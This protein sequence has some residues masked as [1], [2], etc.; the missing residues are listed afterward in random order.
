M[1][2]KDVE[3]LTVIMTA[4]HGKA[5][6]AIARKRALRCKRM[7]ENDWAETWNAVAGRIVD[8]LQKPHAAD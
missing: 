6:E 3:R 5:A 4:R 7:L 8:K 1:N 2:D